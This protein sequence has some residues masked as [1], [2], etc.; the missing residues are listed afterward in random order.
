[1]DHC[2]VYR[3]RLGMTYPQYGRALWKPSVVDVGDVGCI[4]DGKFLRLFNT[5]HPEGHK[6]NLRFGVPD[7]HESLSPGVS[8]H[9]ENDIDDTIKRGHYF[10][11]GVNV[12]HAPESLSTRCCS[13]ATQ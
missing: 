7:N 4:R 5:L 11:S 9:L 1:M 13:Y 2:D 10:S 12:I 3:E 8:D 6:S